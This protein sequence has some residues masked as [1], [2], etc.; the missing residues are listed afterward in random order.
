MASIARSRAVTRAG[1]PVP[2]HRSTIPAAASMSVARRLSWVVG[3]GQGGDNGTQGVCDLDGLGSGEVVK[4]SA[5]LGQ[6]VGHDG[7]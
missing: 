4:A 6:R 2:A 7:G 5:C 1:Q 3:A